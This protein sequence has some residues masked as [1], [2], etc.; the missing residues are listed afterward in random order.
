MFCIYPSLPVI[1]SRYERLQVMAIIIVKFERSRCWIR[2]KTGKLQGV[3]SLVGKLYQLDCEP[4]IEDYASPACEQKSNVDLWHQR[5]GHLSE[6]RLS[7]IS[8]K[9]LVTGIKLPKAT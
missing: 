2:H 5:L 8:H 3:G 6:R 9:D 7:D 1:S 4:T